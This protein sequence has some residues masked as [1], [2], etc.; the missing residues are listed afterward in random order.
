MLIF[1]CDD[2]K[3]ISILGK[4][5]NAKAG[6]IVISD[7]DTKMYYVGTLGSWPDSILGKK[8]KVT[9]VLIIEEIP[10]I[11]PGEELRQQ[12]TGTKLTLTK[13]KWRLMP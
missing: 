6:A 2:V 13:P 1:G 10:A 8:V 9:G 11:A 5:E 4:A 12:I 7:K 3:K